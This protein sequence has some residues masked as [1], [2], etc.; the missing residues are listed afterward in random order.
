[1][2][3]TLASLMILTAGE[4]SWNPNHYI[5]Q[6]PTVL[7]E[8][9]KDT[10]IRALLPWARAADISFNVVWGGETPDITIRSYNSDLDADCPAVANNVVAFTR[11]GAIVVLNWG[12]P[13]LY[14]VILHEVGH[15]LGLSHSNSTENVMWPVLRSY[16]DI[17]EED[18]ARIRQIYGPALTDKVGVTESNILMW[19]ID[20]VSRVWGFGHR[21][22]GATGMNAWTTLCV[23]CPR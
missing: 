5:P 3:T 11:D 13:D 17:G 7:I 4:C 19:W 22:T 21:P 15:V 18:C 6:R 8:E 23:I 1:M 12:S 10:V 2:I 9:H 20:A 14:S 16:E